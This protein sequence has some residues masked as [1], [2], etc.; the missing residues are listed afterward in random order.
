MNASGDGYR[1]IAGAHAR[2]QGDEHMHT[3]AAAKVKQSA[4]VQPACPGDSFIG[5][6][7][8]GAP[9]TRSLRQYSL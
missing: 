8:G 5:S 1:R 2:V 4:S 9:G 3:D 6:A 7:Q